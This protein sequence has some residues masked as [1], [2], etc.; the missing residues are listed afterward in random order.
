M[1][2]S[3]PS[4]S[5][6]G[7]RRTTRCSL[8]R[9]DME[10]MAIIC[11]HIFKW[12]VWDEQFYIWKKQMPI[13]A[14]FSIFSFP[15]FWQFQSLKFSDLPKMFFVPRLELARP[16][17]HWV[18]HNSLLRARYL[19][20]YRCGTI[21]KMAKFC[22]RWWRNNTRKDLYFK[23]PNEIF[24]PKPFGFFLMKWVE[25]MWPKLPKLPLKL[26]ARTRRFQAQCNSSC[27]ESSRIVSWYRRIVEV[28]QLDLALLLAGTRYRG[29]FE[30]L[31]KFSWSCLRPYRS[32]QAIRHLCCASFQE[33]LRAVVK[34]VSESR[35]RVILV[36]DEALT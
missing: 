2:C 11:Q 20:T 4:V 27:A 33:R 22:G 6:G 8:A 26:A 17:L 5:S 28:V 31:K 34:E 16:P 1:S 24:V 25:F 23:N 7:G 14:A 15:W 9:Q 12:Q 29:D 21:P 30:D 35:R 36:V 3:A 13:I 18:L 10:I 32:I 19:W